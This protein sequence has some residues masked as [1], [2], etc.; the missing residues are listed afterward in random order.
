M[1]WRADYL[2]DPEGAEERL[3]R[4]PALLPPGRVVALDRRG[5]VRPW[6]PGERAYRRHEELYRRWGITAEDLAAYERAVA[7]GRIVQN[8][9]A[10]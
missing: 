1:D 3:M 9:A 6:R 10:R 8:D 7:G 5:E 2:R 4:A